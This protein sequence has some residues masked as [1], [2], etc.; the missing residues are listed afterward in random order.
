MNPLIYPFTDPSQI[1]TFYGEQAQAIFT[2]VYV[3]TR[4]LRTSEPET[5][6]WLSE[7]VGN[8]SESAPHR[9]VRRNYWAV[10]KGK[11]E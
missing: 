10:G 4:A 8:I 9:P 1:K 3:C 5:I 11:E 7:L 6:R 2:S